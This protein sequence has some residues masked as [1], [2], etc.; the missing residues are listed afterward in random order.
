MPRFVSLALLLACASL[1]VGACGGDA[2][3]P[4]S[5]T[6][7]GPTSVTET[8]AGELNRNGARTHTFLAQASGTVTATLDTL[9]PDT[10]AAIGLSLGTW[11]G[12]ACQI[13]IANDNAAK[14]A[15]VVGA[16]STAGNLC[17]RVYDVGKVSD[18]TS[19]ALTVVHP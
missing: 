10:T 14:G 13:V 3:V 4:T 5:P 19:Y 7:S 1:P 17:V 2:P 8:F 6:P 15:V 16:A 18:L 12:S 9:A 11:N